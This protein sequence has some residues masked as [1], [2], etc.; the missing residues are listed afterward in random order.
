[1][2]SLLGQHK[3]NCYARILTL[4]EIKLTFCA[5]FDF[6]FDNSLSLCRNDRSIKARARSL[7]ILAVVHGSPINQL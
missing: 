6:S 7:N 3:E 4:Y 2:K 5:L 1:M